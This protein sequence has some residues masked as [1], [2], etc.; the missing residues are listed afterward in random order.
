MRYCLPL[1]LLVFA[2]AATGQTTMDQTVV[3]N[4]TP[5]L[6]PEGATLPQLQVYLHKDE[7]NGFNLQLVVRNY[8]LES[9]ELAGDA[10]NQ[11]LEGHAH[12][13]INGRKRIRLYSEWIHIDQS[14]LRKGTNQLTVTLNSHQHETW[15]ISNQPVLSTVFFDPDMTEPVRHSF[16]S[17]PLKTE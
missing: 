16:S 3:H 14:L 5:R 9:P 2:T 6:V 17:S 15:V 7:S 12:I 11:L 4:H 13:M 1:L 8:Q 10:P